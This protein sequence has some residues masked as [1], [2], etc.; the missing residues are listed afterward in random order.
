MDRNLTVRRLAAV[1]IAAL[2]LVSCSDDDTTADRGSVPADSSAPSTG[3]DPAATPGPGGGALMGPSGDGWTKVL[4]PASC[5]C[6]DGTPFH[7]W[8]RPG[9]PEKVLFF[10]AGGGACFSATTCATDGATYTVNLEGDD[11]PGDDGI[12]DLG[13]E[14]NPLADHSMVVVPYCTGDLHLGTELHDYGDGVEVHHNGFTN[15]STALAASAALFPNA[16]DVVVAGSSAGSAGAP[17]FGGGAHDVWPEADIAVI[18]DASAA[19]PGTPE[20][21]L[22]IGGLWG[23]AGSIPLWPETADLPPEAWSLP[24]LFVNSSLRHPEIRFATYNNAFDRV[25]A[26]F[27][28]LIGQ[29]ADNLVDLIDANNEWISDQGVDVRHWVAPGTDHTV[30]GDEQLY[31]QEVDGMALIDWLAGF[32]AGEDGPDVHCTDCE[33]AG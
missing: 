17:A 25:Q 24:G 29:D 4:A 23:I 14:A 32:L 5:R 9:D 33:A 21:T 3:A 20:I 8:V 15:A 28:S 30:L 27:S 13:N 26:Q 12:F 31:T 6:S 1:L 7:Y 10:L 22:A 16:T 18:A 2:V 11:G 19:Y